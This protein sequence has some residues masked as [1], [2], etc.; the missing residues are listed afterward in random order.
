LTGAAAIDATG[1]ALANTITGN[2]AANVLNGAAGADT[3]LGLAG[4]DTYV[5][6]NP[7][8]TVDESGGSGSD[9]VVS[10]ISFSLAASAHLIGS[11]ERLAL[12]GSAVIN[13][14]GNGL[15]NT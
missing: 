5:V 4:N 12:S 8:D 11:I 14:T 1:N 3:M 9:V 7:L 6:D 10:S 2:A 15:A 13:G